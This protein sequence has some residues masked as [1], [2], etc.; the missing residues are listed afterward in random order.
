MADLTHTF[1]IYKSSRY[2]AVQIHRGWPHRA[3]LR[4]MATTEQCASESKPWE[5]KACDQL[6]AKRDDVIPGTWSFWT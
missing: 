2:L 5:E 1:S 4:R 6:L 3:V